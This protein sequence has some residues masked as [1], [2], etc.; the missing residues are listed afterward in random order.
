[1]ALAIKSVDVFNHAH[2]YSIHNTICKDKQQT[3]EY[4]L[5]TLGVSLLSHHLPLTTKYG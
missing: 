2:L 4:M 1:M 5:N 3:L